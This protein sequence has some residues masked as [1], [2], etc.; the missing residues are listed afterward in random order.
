MCGTRMLA[1]LL[2]VRLPPDYQSPLYCFEPCLVTPVGAVR[3]CSF[4]SFYRVSGAVRLQW[5]HPTERRTVR[6]SA[7]RR[8]NRPDRAGPRLRRPDSHNGRHGQGHKIFSDLQRV[9]RRGGRQVDTYLQAGLPQRAR[10]RHGQVQ[11]GPRA[12]R[13]QRPRR[14]PTFP[15]TFPRPS[16]SGCWRGS[17]HRLCPRRHS[18]SGRSPR[19]P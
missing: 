19:G 8:S 1:G 15:P 5:S 18:A 10:H 3:R 12:P 9:P 6:N 16:S 2:I 4:C 11:H 7:D 14:C 13:R 17:T